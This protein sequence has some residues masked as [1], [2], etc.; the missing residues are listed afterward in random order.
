MIYSRVGSLNILTYRTVDSYRQYSGP[1][2]LAGRRILS[3]ELGAV[4][5]G[6][7]MT[8]FPQQLGFVKRSF[9]GGHN[10]VVLHGAT[11]SHQY[12]NTTWPGFTS[13]QYLFSEQHSRHQPAWPQGYKSLLDFI[14]RTQYILQTGTPKIDLLFYNKV[15]GQNDSFP[16]LYPSNDLNN[17]GQSCQQENRL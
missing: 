9:S 16:S 13:F 10:M 7:Y 6:A 12:P 17:A 3:T 2:H 4:L 11:Y 14:G 1:A 8:T 15:T 5:G